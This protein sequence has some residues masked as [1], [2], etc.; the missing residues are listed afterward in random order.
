LYVVGLARDRQRKSEQTVVCE[1]V[2]SSGTES[3]SDKIEKTVLRSAYYAEREPH[4][5][6]V[7]K[8]VFTKDGRRALATL[9]IYHG[10]KNAQ[11]YNIVLQ[12][13]DGAWRIEA[14]GSPGLPRIYLYDGDNCVKQVDAG[15]H[16][17]APYA[18]GSEAEMGHVFDYEHALEELMRCAVR[19]KRVK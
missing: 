8:V 17:L 5:P 4:P 10:P 16:E 6:S 1:E 3:D 18:Q 9:Q 19:R 12:K 7:D 13:S 2:P 11:G 15:G 14:S